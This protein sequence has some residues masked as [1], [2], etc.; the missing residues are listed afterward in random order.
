M[1]TA[2]VML[3][4]INPQ[5][6]CHCCRHVPG[7]PVTI[8]GTGSIHYSKSIFRPCIVGKCLPGDVHRT[9]FFFRDFRFHYIFMNNGCCDIIGRQGSRIHYRR[10]T[11]R[12]IQ[13]GRV[14]LPVIPEKSQSILIQSFRRLLLI[15]KGVIL[16]PKIIL[17][18][19]Y[20]CP[21]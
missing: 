12:L 20:F 21:Q 9:A 16:L 17:H 13:K 19:L 5:R 1:E 8:H 7:S 6:L 2:L 11:F 3:R 4:K 18:Q 15:R 14:S 10:I